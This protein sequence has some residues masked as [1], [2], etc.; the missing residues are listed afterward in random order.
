MKTPNINFNNQKAVEIAKQIIWLA[1][2]SNYENTLEKAKKLVSNKLNKVTDVE[3]KTNL[4]EGYNM[5]S[6]LSYEQIKDLYYLMKEKSEETLR[7]RYLF[8]KE[9]STVSIN[10]PDGKEE[11][12][13]LEGRFADDTE[14]YLMMMAKEHD[15]QMAPK[16]RFFSYRIN[17]FD[18]SSE[19]LI[20][21]TDKDERTFLARKLAKRDDLE[22]PERLMSDINV[23]DNISHFIYDS[24][25]ND[26][27]EMKQ[28]MKEAVNKKIN[29]CFWA[30]D[31][32]DAIDAYIAIKDKTYD[33]LKEE[34][35][36]IKRL[37]K[38]KAIEER[39]QRARERKIN[40]PAPKYFEDLIIRDYQ[41]KVNIRKLVNKT[42]NNN[43]LVDLIVTNEKGEDKKY[44]LLL[45]KIELNEHTYFKLFEIP[46]MYGYGV[47]YPE[48]FYEYIKTKKVKDD[49]LS[50]VI[51]KQLI[52]TLKSE[53]K[54]LS[55][56]KK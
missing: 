51:D 44:S 28:K 9:G 7:D 21:I 38:M 17:K 45:I 27:Y 48:A 47:P 24:F 32:I 2:S 43:P 54:R 41:N 26:I 14:L 55:K 33:E 31:V 39:K 40:G 4:I 11:L 46:P 35:E 20:E 6:V 16:V 34:Y 29:H 52:K 13:T 50:K 8:I 56:I 5:F 19:K 30:N 36:N 37:R 1:F 42:Y 49:Y 18:Y 25:S 3:E 12:Y 15:S 53:L 10:T 23:R 22:A